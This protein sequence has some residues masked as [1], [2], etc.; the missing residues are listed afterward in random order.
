[1]LGCF[2]ARGSAW[3]CQASDDC[4]NRVD[5]HVLLSF[6]ASSRMP[7]HLRTATSQLRDSR[8]TLSWCGT[9][10]RLLCLPV[11]SD[12][13]NIR[14]LTKFVKRL[15]CVVSLY[16]HLLVWICLKLDSVNV[17]LSLKYQRFS[18][19]NYLN[20][21][22]LKTSS[23]RFEFIL[24]FQLLKHTVQFQITSSRSLIFQRS[25]ALTTQCKSICAHRCAHIGILAEQYSDT[26]KQRYLS[27]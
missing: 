18:Q 7:E 5:V 8:S 26:L 23:A 25:W 13:F 27:V 24:L 17:W 22:F 3:R 14:V 9:H 19:M 20:Y 1:M 4:V 2:I 16:D 11:I 21:Y 15:S 10:L 6:L 12:V